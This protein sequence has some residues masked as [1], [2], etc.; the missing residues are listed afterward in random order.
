MAIQIGDNVY[1]NLQEQVGK[2][3]EDIEAFKKGQRVLAQ[4]GIKMVG[5]ATTVMDIPTVDAYKGSNP[6]WDY[7]DAYAVGTKTPYTYYL[8]TRADEDT[9]TD[10]WF[11]VGLFPAP[12]PKGPGQ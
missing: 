7:G 6:N 10:Y 4:F 12:G 5:R 9:P 3:K 2:N 8:L 1:R 11:P